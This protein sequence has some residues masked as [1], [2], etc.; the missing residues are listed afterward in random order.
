MTANDQVNLLSVRNV[1]VSIRNKEIIKDISLDLEAG[2]WL[3]I[4]GPNGAGKT[5][6]INAI[7]Q[8]VPYS[9]EVSVKGKDAKSYNSIQFA[10]EIGVLSQQHFPG[11]DFTVNDVIRLGCYSH[12][13][14]LFRKGSPQSD[15]LFRN[16]V[17]I[18]GMEEFLD[19]SVLTLSGGE[20]QRTFLAQLFAQDPGI[21]L[22][23]EPTNHL[24]LIY[25]KDTFELISDWLEQES[26]A[27]ISVVHDLSLAKMYGSSALLLADGKVCAYG[28]SY[29]VLSPDVLNDIYSIDVR[30]WMQDLYGQWL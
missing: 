14:G 30:K 27:V 15:E 20:L 17:E 16:A 3:M 24:D 22:L 5:T 13:S 9:G 4:V 23:D 25:Q 28:P 26:R 6:L 12:G 18:T 10:R 21:L 7:S 11:Y 19:R 29:D 8:A 2:Q 1:S